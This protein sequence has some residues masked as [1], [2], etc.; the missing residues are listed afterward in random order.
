[1]SLWT[2][3]DI[4]IFVNREIIGHANSAYTVRGTTVCDVGL[5]V[6]NA[7]ET[8]ARAAS[9]GTRAFSQPTGAGELDIPAIRGLS[10]SVLHFIDD[11]SG[12]SDVWSVEFT[13]TTINQTGAGIKRIDHLAQTMS[14]DEMLSWSLFY[15]SLF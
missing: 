11:A 3:G 13:P 7:A 14:Y 1:M 6:A 10:G 2:Q 9:L 15:T 5:Y 8:V 4:R 12:L